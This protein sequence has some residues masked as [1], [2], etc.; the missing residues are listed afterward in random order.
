[1]LIDP[2]TEVDAQ[3][4]NK[5]AAD[6]QRAYHIVEIIPTPGL[7]HAVPH[8]VYPEAPDPSEYGYYQVDDS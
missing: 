1:M 6:D 7:D 2:Q 4:D 3:C 8:I 5:A